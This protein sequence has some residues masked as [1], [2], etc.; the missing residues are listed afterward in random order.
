M[1]KHSLTL[2]ALTTALL[3]PANAGPDALIK[4]QDLH[5]QLSSRPNPQQLL[6][7]DA[8]PTPRFRAGH[9][10]GAVSADFWRYG[11][12][13]GS[14]GQWQARMR[15]WGIRQ[16]PAQRIVIYDAGADNLATRVYFDLLTHGI[17]AK[18]MQVLDGGLHQW[19]AQGG[20]LQ[21]GEGQAPEPG[22]MTAQPADPRWLAQLPEFVSLSGEPQRGRLVEALDPQN[23]FGAQ[24]W[25]DRAGH[26]PNALMLPHTELFNADR[27]FRAPEE[28]SR[29]LQHLGL[30]ADQPA[31]SYC[32]GGVAGSV[33]FFAMQALLDWPQAKLYVGSQREY[34]LD[35]RRL[36]L[37]QYAQRS[38][39]RDR[40]W[41]AGW[42]NR[43]MRQ[44]GATHLTVLDLR[45]AEAFQKERLPGAIHLPAS[46]WQQHRNE[47]ARLADLLA[48]AGARPDREL[49]L[50]GAHS[51]LSPDK[52][53]ALVLLHDLG[54]AQAS[55]LD[56]SVD[57][58]ALAG[59]DMEKGA[60][61]A[62]TAPTPAPRWQAPAR[63]L[64]TAQIPSP[65]AGAHR[66][67]LGPTP[68][69]QR[70]GA[71]LR[72][73]SLLQANGQPQPAWQLWETLRKV[74]VDRYAELL[75]DLPD[76]GEAAQLLWLLQ[77]AGM[78]KVQVV[79]R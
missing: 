64:R 70:P 25:F 21:Q 44:F 6:L 52:A 47:P 9:I 22:D 43:L 32:G 72:A 79:Q 30:R 39:L 67:W 14:A 76:S 75:V 18:R 27:T 4:A 54:H 59:G 74:G 29:R 36:P 19:Q 2:L 11:M 42:N 49:V 33:P 40:A 28:L 57:D 56:E 16:D 31:I 63:S 41:L 62:R 66:Q 55:A 15:G 38:P 5:Q 12:N 45:E 46:L 26:V 69:A 48:Q 1:L 8:S 3:S 17:P 7:L 34:L 58:W 68:T 60:P 78:P 73:S 24:Q 20:L 23:Y 50:V 51:G 65:S 35:E 13:P 10:P 61:N 53:L 77:L 71:A 37:W